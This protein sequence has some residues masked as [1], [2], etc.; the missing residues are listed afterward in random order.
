MITALLLVPVAAVLTW[1]YRYSLPPQQGW[2]TFD[3]GLLMILAL[4]VTAFGAWVSG[5]SFEGAGPIWPELL[6]ALGGYAII[7]G[8]LAAGLTWRRHRACSGLSR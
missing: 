1:L 6:A 2:R 8:G 4:A 7:A 3:S 5:M